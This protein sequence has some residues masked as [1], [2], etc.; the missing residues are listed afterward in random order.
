MQ[1]PFGATDVFC[2]ASDS[3]MNAESATFQVIVQDTTAP[4]ITR[5]SATPGTLWPPDHKMVQVTIFVEISDGSSFEAVITGV[6]SSENDPND[7]T[8]PDWVITGP[9]TLNLRSEKSE[10]A[11]Q[12]VY[13]ITVEVTDD[14]NVTHEK[15]VEVTVV[16]P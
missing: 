12:R 9:L 5:S 13:T 6:V 7:N 14:A 2:T 4:A 8:S 15:T 16:K 1:F 10:Q 3:R 11:Q